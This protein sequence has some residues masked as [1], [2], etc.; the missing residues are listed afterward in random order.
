MR[1]DTDLVKH[2]ITGRRPR[3]LL[4]KLLMCV[5]R[6]RGPCLFS[7][8]RFFCIAL[9]V[10]Q[11]TLHPHSG[12]LVEASRSR[13]ETTTTMLVYKLTRLSRTSLVDTRRI[14]RRVNS[15]P[16]HLACFAT[17]SRCFNFRTVSYS[18]QIICHLVHVYLLLYSNLYRALAS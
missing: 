6:S 8:N 15:L 13:T 9:Y 4:F 18:S 2:A 1:L 17:V 10:L 12:M 7:V 3:H 5:R 11:E 14:E 16:S